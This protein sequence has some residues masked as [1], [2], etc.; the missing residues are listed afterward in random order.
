VDGVTYNLAFNAENKVAAVTDQSTAEVT[1][2]VYD[3]CLS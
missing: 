3:G 2:F 1:T